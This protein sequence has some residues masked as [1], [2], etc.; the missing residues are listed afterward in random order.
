M[1]LVM[2]AVVMFKF[3]LYDEGWF[4]MN[5]PLATKSFFITPSFNSLPKASWGWRFPVF[6]LAVPQGR[7]P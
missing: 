6:M 7:H 5:P 3:F 2:V 1:L 4:N